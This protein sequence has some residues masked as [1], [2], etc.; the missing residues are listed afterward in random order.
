[1]SLNT[2]LGRHRILSDAFLQRNLGRLPITDGRTV[3]ETKTIIV[4]GAASGIG[5]ATALHLRRLGARVIGV[6]VMDCPDVDEFHRADL[7]DPEGIDALV[8]ALPE[9]AEGLCNIAGVPPTAPAVDVLRV[10]ARGLQ[11]LT[12]RLVPRLADGASIVNLASLAGNRWAES[13]E[14][15]REFAGVDFAEIP[16]FV[17]RHGMDEGPRSYFFSKE[18]VVAWTFLNRWRWRERGIRMNAVSPGPVD[19]PILDDFLST[20]GERA[21]EAL[22]VMDRHGRPEDIAPVIAFLLDD[23]AAW[24]RGANLTPDGGMSSHY[25]MRATGLE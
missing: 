3:P 6:D 7:G 18:Y 1:V 2:T 19:T 5:R 20:L 22:R 9:G 8:A 17:A 12:E 13:V 24:F 23:E 4:T 10:N 15:I 16:A 25:L 11:Y 21:D 14:Q